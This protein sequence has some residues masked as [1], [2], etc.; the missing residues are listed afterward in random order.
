MHTPQPGAPYPSSW[1]PTA[2]VRWPGSAER[3]ADS[4][5][6]KSEIEVHVSAI[7]TI[8]SKISLISLIALLC[9]LP[10]SAMVMQRP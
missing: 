8:T 7:G 10:S 5:S 3:G 1:K 4:N 2:A 9:A 6:N